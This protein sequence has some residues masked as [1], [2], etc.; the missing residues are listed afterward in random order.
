M[1]DKQVVVEAK[2]VE[3][4]QVEVKE[5]KVDEKAVASNAADKVVEPERKVRIHLIK[6]NLNFVVGGTR[7][8]YKKGDKN[9]DVPLTVWEVI[10]N[11]GYL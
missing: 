8:T 3:A 11:A 1:S 4:K 7:Y 5:A 2:A 9:I 6:H 10:A